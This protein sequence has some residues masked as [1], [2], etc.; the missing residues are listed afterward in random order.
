ME[1]QS[2]CCRKMFHT[3]HT[4]QSCWKGDFNFLLP[5]LWKDSMFPSFIP[6]LKEKKDSSFLGL[7]AK[8]LLYGP[9]QDRTERLVTDSK[10]IS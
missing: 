2:H 6:S 4:S 9:S 1:N 7:R 5:M 10:S 3:T 8:L